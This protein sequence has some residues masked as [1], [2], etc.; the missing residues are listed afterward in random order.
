MKQGFKTRIGD[1]ERGFTLIELLV[2][3]LILGILMAIAIPTFLNLTGG[4]KSG[5]A[6]ADLTTAVQDETSYLATNS[7]FDGVASPNAAA[8]GFASDNVSGPGGMIATDPGVNWT[9]TATLAAANAGKKIV[10]VWMSGTSQTSIILGAAGSNGSYY[11]VYDNFGLLS[12]DINTSPAVPT[13]PTG[14]PGATGGWGV[15]WKG[16]TTV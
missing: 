6:E 7:D 8:G 3:V 16:A 15:N 10:L 14:A 11:W 13:V 9:S 12:F 1:G 4:A 5:A 2:V